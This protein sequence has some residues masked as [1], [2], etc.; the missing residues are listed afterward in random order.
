MKL[1]L[2]WLE[3][4]VASIGYKQYANTRVPLNVTW[5]IKKNKYI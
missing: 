5:K 3:L 2:L 4:N 1:L